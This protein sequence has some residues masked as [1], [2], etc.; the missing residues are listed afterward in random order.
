ML[1]WIPVTCATFNNS[2]FFT[3]A[4]NA[5]LSRLLIDQDIGDIVCE[6]YMSLHC[7]HFYI[8]FVPLKW[9]CWIFVCCTE[10]CSIEQRNI[11]LLACVFFLQFIKSSCFIILHKFTVIMEVRS[12]Y[13]NNEMKRYWYFVSH[14]LCIWFD[15]V[16]FLFKWNINSRQNATNK[17]SSIP[18][19]LFNNFASEM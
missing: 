7:A 8:Y 15:F 18:F 5:S 10:T 6:L 4:A 2:L 1:V 12:K 13:N 17:K 9:Y 16:C 19:G 11:I 3:V 14:N